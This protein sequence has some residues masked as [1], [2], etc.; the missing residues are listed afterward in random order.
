[1]I[2]G[3]EGWED[4]FRPPIIR[5]LAHGVTPPDLRHLVG[6]KQQSEN[7]KTMLLGIILLRAAAEGYW[8]DTLPLFEEWLKRNER[9]LWGAEPATGSHGNQHLEGA[10]AILRACRLAK[11]KAREARVLA[12]LRGVLWIYASCDPHRTGESIYPGARSTGEARGPKAWR[13]N[14]RQS[15]AGRSL[16][17]WVY[18][19]KD[20]GPIEKAGGAD[21]G[22][23]IALEV[24]KAIAPKNVTKPPKLRDGPLIV[25]VYERGHVASMPNLKAFRPCLLAWGL[26]DGSRLID[27]GY[28]V[29]TPAE[30]GEPIR[31]LRSA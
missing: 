22:A 19:G 4:S 26:V 31:E 14:S 17:R 3:A 28:D 20:P 1:M 9:E 2:D 6:G 5:A 8:K 15:G 11:D 27:A 21:G 23:M 24:G 10:A 18:F 16:Y 7:H 29:E 12:L 13:S 30:L 25:T